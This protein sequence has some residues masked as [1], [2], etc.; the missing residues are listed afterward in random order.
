M[1]VGQEIDILPARFLIKLHM[2]YLRLFFFFGLKESSQKILTVSFVTIYYSFIVLFFQVETYNFIIFAGIFPWKRFF[3][4]RRLLHSTLSFSLYIK[5]L[6]SLTKAK[7]IQIWIKNQLGYPFKSVTRLPPGTS[8]LFSSVII[9]LF[10]FSNLFILEMSL[11]FQSLSREHWVWGGNAYQMG[12]QLI[13]GHFSVMKVSNLV[14]MTGTFC[15]LTSLYFS[16]CIL[17]VSG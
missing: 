17:A 14:L 15:A 6:T 13:T 8:S 3:M 11:W 16:H 12:H 1:Y 7:C 4:C 9:H 5:P 10:I 2:L